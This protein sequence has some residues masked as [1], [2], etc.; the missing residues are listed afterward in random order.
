MRCL[1]AERPRR[2]VDAVRWSVVVA[3]LGLVAC[4]GS[5]P[6]ET[7]DE[8]VPK[9]YFDGAWRYT[10]TYE[11]TG[12]APLRRHV[13]VT[14]QEQLVLFYEDGSDHRVV[15]ALGIDE[16]T[17][18]DRDCDERPL[19]SVIE[20][21]ALGCPWYLRPNV[22]LDPRSELYVL[23]LSDPRV[24]EEVSVEPTSWELTDDHMLFVQDVGVGF[25]HDRAPR[26]VTVRHDFERID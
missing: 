4:G 13:R 7:L 9:A 22:V 18:T 24:T 23:E 15:W 11:G 5:A 2:E 19:T 10:R 17:P 6:S 14:M 12:F 1:D 25:L 26:L 20:D 21:Y 8:G 3:L 16:H